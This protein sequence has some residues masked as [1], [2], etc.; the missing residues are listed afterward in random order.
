M[1]NLTSNDFVKK[2][3][4]IGAVIGQLYVQG[5]SPT[6]P[7]PT[8]KGIWTEL[9]PDVTKDANYTMTQMNFAYDIL[10]EENKNGNE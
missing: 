7:V 1:I 6:P 10:V 3:I 5:G 2:G 8:S 4:S 9:Y